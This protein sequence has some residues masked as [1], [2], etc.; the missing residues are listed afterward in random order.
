LGPSQGVLGAAA[1]APGG[2]RP[3]RAPRRTSWHP[4]LVGDLAVG[5]DGEFVMFVVSAAAARGQPGAG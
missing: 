1:K 2:Y 3:G 5:G 4:H